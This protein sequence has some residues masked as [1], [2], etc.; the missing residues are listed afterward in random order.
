MADT[1]DEVGNVDDAKM[2]IDQKQKDTSAKEHPSQDKTASPIVSSGNLSNVSGLPLALNRTPTKTTTTITTNSSARSS[3]NNTPSSLPALNNKHNLSINTNINSPVLGR[4]ISD[5]NISAFTINSSSSTGISTGGY[6][7]GR[8]R[9]SSTSSTSSHLVNYS[10]NSTDGHRSRFDS[11]RVS[12][13]VISL[14]HSSQNHLYLDDNIRRLLADD[15]NAA[16]THTNG[17]YNNASLRD[18]QTTH[19]STQNY[20]IDMKERSLGDDDDDGKGNHSFDLAGGSDGEDDDDGEAFIGYIGADV[21]YTQIVQGNTG[22][23]YIVKDKGSTGITTLAFP[24]STTNAS[25]SAFKPPR[26]NSGSN[27]GS[28]PNELNSNNNN[29]EDSLLDRDEASR[30]SL[31]SFAQPSFVMPQGTR[32]TSTGANVGMTDIAG[33]NI[34][35]TTDSLSPVSMG[36]PSSHE[37]VGYP[38]FGLTPRQ[39]SVVASIDDGNATNDNNITNTS[40]VV[41]RDRSSSGVMMTP[42]HHSSTYIAN[43]ASQQATSLLYGGYGMDEKQ[44]ANMLQDEAKRNKEYAQQVRRL[45]WPRDVEVCI[46]LSDIREPTFNI[47][48]YKLDELVVGL[49]RVLVDLGFKQEVN[50]D[51]D[52]VLQ[53]FILAVRSNYRNNPFHNFVHGFHVFQ[54]CFF[55]LFH[56]DMVSVL[57]T[58]RPGDAM[59]PTDYANLHGSISNNANGGGGSSSGSNAGR[60]FTP[61]SATFMQSKRRSM[62]MGAAHLNLS[63]SSSTTGGGLGSRRGNPIYTDPQ[64]VANILKNHYSCLSRLE[65]F[66]LLIASLCHDLDH[67]GTNNQYQINTSSPLALLHNDQSVLENHHATM[68]FTLL[69]NPKLN[70][71]RNVRPDQQRVVRKTIVNA[72]L[73]T[74]MSHHMDTTKQLGT[75]DSPLS[76]DLKSDKDKSFLFG[77]IIHTSDL[78][79]QTLPQPSAGEWERRINEEFR[80]QAEDEERLGL[81]VAPFMQNL[82]KTHVRAQSQVNFIDFVLAPW[83]RNLVRLFPALQ[84]CADTLQE[85]RAYYE[86]IYKR[87]LEAFK[88]KE[89]EEAAAADISEDMVSPANSPSSS[90]SSPSSPSSSFSPTSSSPSSSASN[91][92][93]TPTSQNK[94]GKN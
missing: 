6:N 65:L 29:T 22:Y 64:T 47:F 85:N 60:S 14:P 81:P 71:F 10:D 23:P 82:D 88:K 62:T 31:T 4:Q 1:L 55:M 66:C 15:V 51:D 54:F 43:V 36:V 34:G 84:M 20:S 61:L 45:R 94:I 37:G 9:S 40:H 44:L 90:P 70:V 78:C 69:R 17:D 87:E 52:R 75:V 86:G 89:A 93:P 11:F 16:S 92:I 21:V 19:G 2:N 76:L 8:E 12:R 33:G 26:S 18:S 59:F 58:S 35:M 80:K 3:N 38:A 27:V 42:S 7:G 91:K 5:R 39:G 56:S 41:T 49:Y 24:T 28:I 46:S 48:N 30:I 25:M 53:N 63:V 73:A 57:E 79:A 67:P 72:I 68:T 77:V 32:T 83:W 13:S 50:L 74:D